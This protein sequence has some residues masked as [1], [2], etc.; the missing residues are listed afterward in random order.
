M[1]RIYLTKNRK[2]AIAINPTI[3]EIFLPKTFFDS[4][5][6][7]E[8]ELELILPDSCPDIARLIR[9]DC[10]PFCDGCE[11]QNGDARISG[12]AVY[13][14]L[15]EC[16]RKNKLKCCTQVQDFSAQVS[17]PKSTLT[18]LAA[19]AEIKCKKISCKLTSPRNA[20][21]KATLGIR[22][23]AEGCE[24][25][26]ALAVT[27]EEST[28][29][30]KK[31]IGFD[32]K[33]KTVVKDF[34]FSDICRLAQ[35]EK[36]INEI[37][38][39]TMELQPPQLTLSP[40]AAV[41]KTNGTV[42]FLYEDEDAEGEYVMS[43]KSIPVALKLEEQSISDFKNISASLS[44]TH[45]T[46]FPELDEY[47]ENRCAKVSFGIRLSVSVC[48][49]V[50]YTVAK[51]VF[52]TD[53][54]VCPELVHATFCRRDRCE[55][56][57]FASE[58]RL[59]VSEPQISEI[60]SCTARNFGTAC[61]SSDGGAEVFGSF[62]VTVLARTSEGVFCFDHSIPYSQFFPLENPDTVSRITAE[63][64]HTD[65]VPTLHS[66]GSISARII[67]TVRICCHREYTES[68]VSG[69]LRKKE[70]TATKDD[71]SVIFCYPVEGD[72]GWSLAKRYYVN[73]TL[74]SEANPEFF[75]ENGALIKKD[76][77]L[78]IEKQA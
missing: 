10:T 54:E 21:L 43:T 57:S 76:R 49:P 28:F 74:L 39:G 33:R 56:K 37:V 29:F 5:V 72:T 51:D 23:V 11:L 8:I 58:A 2:D 31:V 48:E 14:L 69:D 66:D 35:G 62:A 19:D 45:V 64:T 4:E 1:T 59:P 75:S 67:A 26:S 63:I 16:E 40:G 41:L 44:P 20:V 53:C 61:N 68:F 47:G 42:R 18:E 77:P 9:V 36:S 30:D 65:T 12:R 6:D 15:Y 55:E 32:G 34:E 17:L 7:H 3:N 13:D 52:S 24:S 50:A 22:I 27:E 78:I 38:C 46:F 25:I 60:L 70:L 71:C 73:P